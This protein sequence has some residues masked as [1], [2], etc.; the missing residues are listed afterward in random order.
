MKKT[1]LS[2]FI[3]CFISLTA[4]GAT[5]TVDDDGP[6]DFRKIQD[7]IDVSND[8]D[9]IVVA[10][11]N[12][13][14]TINFMGKAIRVCSRDSNDWNVVKNTIIHGGLSGSGAVFNS[15]E[16]NNSILEGFTITDGGGTFVNY[17][18]GNCPDKLTFIDNIGGGVLC[19]NSSPTIIRCNISGN[20]LLYICWDWLDEDG[21]LHG[22]CFNGIRCGGGIALWGRCSARITNCVISNN[23]VSLKGGGIFVF[24]DKWYEPNRPKPVIQNCTIAYNVKDNA[25]EYDVDCFFSSP[26]ITNSIIWGNTQ[27]SLLIGDFSTVTYSCLRGANKYQ[28]Y[29]NSPSPVDPC[30]VTLFGSNISKNPDFINPVTDP[31]NKDISL[32]DYH[33]KS[34]SPCIDSGDPDFISINNETDIDGQKRIMTHRVD[35]GA[36]EFRPAIKVT[37]PQTGDLWEYGSIHIIEWITTAYN[38]E[39]VDMFY[40]MDGGN[41]WYLAGSF[42]DNTG[43]YKWYCPDSA[44]DSNDCL[45]KIVPSV[46]D[47]NV[48]CI[49][50]GHFKVLKEKLYPDSKG[51]WSGL[52]GNF[53]RQGLSQYSGPQLGCVKWVFDT[54]GPVTSSASIGEDGTIYAACE[55][56]N[57]YAIDPNGTLIW[58][59]DTNDELISSPS[60]GTDGTIFVGGRNGI[61]YAIDKDGNLRWTHST[62][63]WIYSSPAVAKN[64]KVFVGSMDGKLY[65]L[66][67]DGSELWQFQTSGYGSRTTGSIIASPAID[68]NGTI[69]LMS[70]YDPN[71]YALDPNNGSVKWACNLRETEIAYQPYGLSSLS[72]AVG[73][74]GTIYV[75]KTYDPNLYAI[76]PDNGIIK[77]TVNL[78]DPC[79]PWF[80]PEFSNK[81]Y[82]IKTSWRLGKWYKTDCFSEPVIGPDGTIY[83][84]FD[85]PFLRAVDPNGS[86][87]WVTRLGM[88]GGFTM[89][90]SSDGLIY[91]SC[92]DGHLYV[93]D[94]SGNELSRFISDDMLSWPVLAE[95]ETLIV[96]D[97]K[98]RIWSISLSDCISRF[99]LHRPEDLFGDGVINFYD[100][101]IL[102][103]NWL[104]CTDRYLSYTLDGPPRYRKPDGKYFNHCNYTGDE[105]YFQGDV[106]MNLYIDKSDFVELISNWLGGR[107]LNNIPPSVSLIS[108]NNGD[109]YLTPC[110]VQIEVDAR[111]SDGSVQW[112]EFFF[113]G[114]NVGSDTD[115]SDGWSIAYPFQVDWGNPS[116]Y[117]HITARAVDN[118][119]SSGI[120]QIV[121]ISVLTDPPME[122]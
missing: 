88:V 71:L 77:W 18:V 40:S 81:V 38:E 44:F 58:K 113:N 112:V 67:S 63:G 108:P 54:N 96:S 84:S 62:G 57:L 93:V 65:A 55:D 41:I 8:S 27:R 70:L 22:G 5:Y 21:N 25:N 7:A 39:Y 12:Y 68:S 119:Y 90:V 76:K 53:T 83:V 111:D 33:L 15:G 120:S 104:G 85:D 78:A 69:Y 50:S 106:D 47:S 23:R 116:I 122:E 26:V 34:S 59:Y 64:G 60:L 28:E 107:N 87:K 2:S 121:K 6:A 11:G 24:D 20:G 16:D 9:T 86:I 13:S 31:V 89:S 29:C 103:N 37:R 19:Y 73:K 35:I 118:E 74:D 91:A 49:P 10:T 52:G 101:A 80:G 46:P 94:S 79:S 61:L 14:G 51:K 95:N 97:S 1:I 117:I 75:V 56:G 4:F 109:I 42:I 115:G 3:V 100:I 32:A 66:G 36:D 98:N 30:D 17:Q 110:V 45:I 92:D 43:S 114:Q 102:A 72:P 105:I 82:V 48:L 99:D